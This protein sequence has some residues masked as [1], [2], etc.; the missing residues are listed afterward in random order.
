MQLLY[1]GKLP[2]RQY[3]DFSLKLLVFQMLQY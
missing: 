1:L 3:H 2:R